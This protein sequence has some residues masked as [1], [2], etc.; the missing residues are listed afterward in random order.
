M[1]KKFIYLACNCDPTGSKNDLC[2]SKSGQ[3]VC[4]HGYTGH[5]CNQCK[6]GY[7]SFPNCKKCECN[8][9][10][11]N[12]TPDGICLDCSFNTDGF[13]CERCKIGYFGDPLL[14]NF[15]WKNK[16]VNKNIFN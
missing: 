6:Q 14:G 3:C 12:C 13:N 11:N 16:L 5:K 10:S 7:F 9:F 1:N 15:I 2:D 4:H 8:G